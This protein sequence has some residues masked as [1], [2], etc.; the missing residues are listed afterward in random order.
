M[1]WAWYLAY[2]AVPLLAYCAVR[3]LAYCVVQYLAYC[4]KF[5]LNVRLKSVIS[6]ARSLSPAQEYGSYPPP[7]NTMSIPAV[8]ARALVGRVK[9]YCRGIP[10]FLRDASLAFRLSG[11][12]LP[13]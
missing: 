5:Y 1:V 10:A 3:C 6:Y 12:G 4:V 9:V 8:Y 2:S 13:H 7:P 11:N